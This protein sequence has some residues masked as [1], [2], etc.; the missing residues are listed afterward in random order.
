MVD[1]QKRDPREL[2]RPEDDVRAELTPRWL[3]VEF[4]H[5]LIANSR[6]ALLVREQGRT[7][8]YY[9]PKEDVNFALL[10]KSEKVSHDPNKG[11][12]VH[13][14][15]EVGK[16]SAQNAAFAHPEPQS[17]LPELSEYISFGWDD[18]DAWYEE[19]EQVFVHPK[20]PYKRVDILPSSRHVR[21]ELDGTVLAE[22]Q[23]PWLLFETWLPTRY[24]LPP[25]DVHAEFLQPSDSHSSCPYKG[26]ASYY[27]VVINGHKHKDL[28]WV[29]R[30]PTQESA[31]IKGLFAF[32]N[33]KVDLYVD[34]EL[35]ERPETPWS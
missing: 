9:F 28:I 33:E 8:T 35:Q 17:E 3:R 18:M 26:N 12:T 15:V 11:K 4:N 2:F 13:W 23:R 1:K 22:S 30:E 10:Q 25:E 20:D 34:G 29:Y 6:R 24:Y 7:P 5:K 27:S 14:H 16:R 32:F 19:D 31:R 21:I